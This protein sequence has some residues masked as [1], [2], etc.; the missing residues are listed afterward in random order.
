M[1][2]NLALVGGAAV[3]AFLAIGASAH[4]FDDPRAYCRVVRTIDAPTKD[5]H[6]AGPQVPSWMMAALHDEGQANGNIYW[7]CLKGRVMACIWRTTGSCEKA[8]NF[9][10]PSSVA[11]ECRQQIN[12]ICVPGT[13]CIYSCKDGNAV[14]SSGS[15]SDKRGFNPKDW[16]IVH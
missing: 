1:K 4:T 14:V 9:S 15:Y 5:P 3:V 16:Q 10:V 6:Y 11:D 12:E 7:R 8:S 13:H 2:S